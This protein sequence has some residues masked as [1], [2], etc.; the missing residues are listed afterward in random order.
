MVITITKLDLI[1]SLI[2]RS[3][4]RQYLYLIYNM[5]TFLPFYVG[6]TDNLERRLEQHR[7]GI[8]NSDVAEHHLYRRLVSTCKNKGIT[9]LA[10]A[11][12][13]V[14]EIPALVYEYEA[15]YIC[16]LMRVYAL[17]NIHP[18]IKVYSTID[19]LHGQMEHLRWW[20]DEP[21]FCDALT[22]NDGKLSY[23]EV[24][25]EIRRRTGTAGVQLGNEARIAA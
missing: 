7:E 4:N 11:P 9:R 12:I 22:R 17:I 13:C 10:F 18:L 20:D 6:R 3:T 15:R 24:F 16:H 23:A 5:D 8:R 1:D 14:I 2:H 19:Y 25:R 21:F